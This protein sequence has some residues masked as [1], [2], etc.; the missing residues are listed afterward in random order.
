M[1]AA[2]VSDA[3]R[4]EDR[5]PRIVGGPQ[6]P[7]AVLAGKHVEVIGNGSVG[8]TV[9]QHL[10]R[11]GIGAMT[12]VD[13]SRFKAASVLTH[14]IE[15][16]AIG[17]S[18][19]EYAGAVARALQPDIA[20]SIHACEFQELP[21]AGR[22]CDAVI[23]AVDNL[24]T[25]VDVAQWCLRRGLPL[26]QCSVHGGTMVATVRTFTG[27]TDGQGACIACGYNAAEWQQVAREPRYACD[28][29]G[30]SSRSLQPTRSL[31]SL[32]SLAAELGVHRVLRH[33]L[34]FGLPL[35]DDVLEYRG[36]TDEL[37]T[38]ALRRNPACRLEHARW[39]E[40]DRG[41]ATTLAAV[42][43]VAAAAGSA[44]LAID[45]R[46]FATAA[47]C[48]CGTTVELGRFVAAAG[49]RGVCAACG[50]E[51]QPSPFHERPRVR[52]ADLAAQRPLADLG[53]PPGA[54]IV[55]REPDGRTTLVHDRVA[56][57]GAA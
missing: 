43:A 28:G 52:L 13:R 40:T 3:V 6:D 7:R 37:V 17:R 27:G 29:S 26:V 30:E 16:A 25:E 54:A 20:V 56:R 23:L 55:V 22:D 49:A 24:G 51:L 21:L 9:V 39:A 44:L 38:T 31:S 48:A 47:A 4:R 15:P 57:G 50:G 10:A 42:P 1:D 45:G 12:L 35:A 41:G 19:A 11:A 32:C 5:M 18:K 8:Q 33:L 36:H 53:I 46:V 34:G 2:I 14:P